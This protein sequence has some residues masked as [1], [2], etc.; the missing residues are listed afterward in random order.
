MSRIPMLEVQELR[1]WTKGQKIVP[2]Q[3]LESHSTYQVQ[4]DMNRKRMSLVEQANTEEA[5]LNLNLPPN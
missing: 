5:G 1:E 3:T 4:M 2:S